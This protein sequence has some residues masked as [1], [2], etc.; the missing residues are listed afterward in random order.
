M[1]LQPKNNMLPTI[2]VEI[3][4]Q[5]YSAEC[6][7]VSELLESLYFRENSSCGNIDYPKPK[8]V[9]ILSLRRNT[10]FFLVISYVSREIRRCMPEKENLFTFKVIC[11]I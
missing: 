11:F 6:I 2:P 3:V 9:G 1:V 8:S 7:I 4:M 10:H 5:K